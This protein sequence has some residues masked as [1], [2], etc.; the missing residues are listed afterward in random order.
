MRTKIL[1]IFLAFMT[2]SLWAADFKS[3]DL[4]YNITSSSEPYSVE[5]TCENTTVNN[6]R[7]LES[8]NIP[9]SVIY[10]GIEYAVTSI[11]N[12]AF[13]RCTSLTSIIIPNTISTIGSS[14]FYN[15]KS[16]T[17][18]TIPESVCEIGKEAFAECTNLAS[19]NIPEGIET[20]SSG[21]LYG[22]TTLASITI[23]ASVT[24]IGKNA[25]Y[26]CYFT[27][28]NFVN[29]SSCAMSDYWGPTIVDEEVDGLL[30]RDSIV[31][32][33]RKNISTALIP[34]YVIG[35]ADEAFVLCDSLTSVV[36]PNSVATIGDKAFYDC[37]ALVSI[38]IGT[39]ISHIGYDSFYN[40]GFYNDE[41]NWID[42]VLFIDN[43][44]IKA[45]TS[46]SG[47]YTMGDT[48][49]V[50][51][52]GAFEGCS[53]VTSI[54]MSCSLRGIGVKAFHGCSSLEAIE[55][56][57]GVTTI[58]DQ[59]FYNCS[60]LTAIIW[61]AKDCSQIWANLT[62]PSPLPGMV[63]RPV[64]ED[65]F[66]GIRAQIT[67]LTLGD[68][69][70]HIPSHLCREMSSLK[71]IT[72]P[73]N[74]KSIG[75]TAFGGCSSLT[76]ITIPEGVTD[77]GKYAFDNCSSL[78]SI[79]IPENVVNIGDGAFDGCS[80]LSSVVWNARKCND[81]FE[82]MAIGGEDCIPFES[83][84]IT[85]IEFGDSV[86]HIP[87]LLCKGMKI[88]SVTIPERVKSIGDEAFSGCGLLTSISIPDNVESIGNSAFSGCDSLSSVVIGNGV[89]STG[90]GTFAH[91]ETL[92]EITIGSGLES[93][94]VSAFEYCPSIT[95]LTIPG[96]VTSIGSTAF[97]RCTSLETVILNEGLTS[98]GNRAFMSCTSL[99][100]VNIPNSVTSIEE[101]AFMATSL[102]SITIPENITELD[103]YVFY[104]CSLLTSVVWNAIAANDIPYTNSAPFYHI[105]SQITSFT[106]GDKVAHIP[107]YL[108]YNMERLTSITLPNS[109]TSI[110]DYAFR[111]CSNIANVVIGDSVTSI[112]KYAFGDCRGFTSF[113]IPGRATNIG[114][115]AFK[116][117][118]SL[119]QIDFNGN[120]GDW[121]NIKF[122]SKESNP[123][124]YAKNLHI[125]GQE[126]TDVEI[127]NTI[128]SIN[129]YAFFGCAK[130]SSLV[131]PKSVTN[132]GEEAFGECRRLYDIYCYA[133]V[134]PMASE[135]SFANYNVNLYVPS[136]SLRDYQ[137][138]MVFGSFKFIQPIVSDEY[139]SITY[140]VD[141]EIYATDSVLCG[142]SIVLIETPTK[143]GYTFSGWSEIPETMPAND[144]VVNGTFSVNTY[145]VYYYV[146]DE[147]VHTV[148]VAYGETIPEYVYEPTEEGYTFLGWEGDTYETMPAHDV[149]YTANIDNGIEQLTIH[150]SQLT[151][152]DLS[153][154]KVTDTEN[155]KGGIYI[156]N[157]QKVLIK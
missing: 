155:L 105:L 147:L 94:G 50:I 66:G 70:E 152:Y 20:I 115:G 91:C 30:I 9:T 59:A 64:I 151:I 5:V 1:T 146:G 11:G 46:L 126:I 127:P 19:I 38:S 68:D 76:S 107:A 7:G 32:N 124:C 18:I 25:F 112:G 111:G 140:I 24:E 78:T 35:I 114:Q 104:G 98:I 143:E 10:D 103:N 118:T 109:V 79:T 31:V 102:T 84:Y 71:S 142:E 37:S 128:Y 62:P 34:A 63:G 89:K 131:I 99:V 49:L 28:A 121:C 44:I 139:Y 92:S 90:S 52:G 125:N 150:N 87:A 122:E 17:S 141:G 86:E 113:T 85:S 74:L 77:I 55:I 60:K 138:D 106:F 120:I 58:G 83:Y 33:S 48:V 56:P 27:E 4:Y 22:G 12:Y 101:G 123:N 40:T 75:T 69:I 82:N 100:D 39:G 117:C 14:A 16:L 154:R 153:G 45:Q 97:Y 29:N 3:G 135:N 156:V 65:A 157:G 73:E 13:Y 93:I 129:D 133:T 72:L 144:I 26:G 148:E 43:C 95:S 15:C 21:F 57:A 8:I 54:E 134:P 137:M 80:S 108:C 130:L 36:I 47:A 42:G 119:A 51:A 110:G 53:S 41:S 132:I 81:F 88:T 116:G 67:S 6:Y 136:E 23:P 149:T 61:K 145:K 2:T 96:N